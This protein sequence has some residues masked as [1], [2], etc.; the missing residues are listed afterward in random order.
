M[1]IIGKT[2]STRDKTNTS[3]EFS[4]WLDS[5]EQVNPT[6]IVVT[7]NSDESQSQTYGLVTRIENMSDS[8]SHLDNFV[9]HDF[10]NPTID[11][12]TQRLSTNVARCAVLKN[13]EDIYMPVISGCDVAFADR[14]GILTALGV[15]EVRDTNSQFRELPIGIIEQ[16][17]GLQA[18]AII[19]ARYLLGPEG[20]H[21]NISGI[22]G[23]AA[24]TSY[25]M[26]LL[27]VLLQKYMEDVAV[28]IFNVKQDDLLYIDQS[29]DQELQ[30]DQ[31]KLWDTLGMQP[32]QFQNVK[33]FLPR[34][35]IGRR[36]IVRPNTFTSTPP[37]H[38]MYAYDLRSI[39]DKLSYL[40]VDVADPRDALELLIGDIMEDLQQQN[41]RIRRGS[42]NFN[43]QT[44]VDLIN[45]FSGE[46]GR[47]RGVH[48]PQTM[49]KF[50]RHMRHFTQTGT[51]GLFVNNRNDDEANL[52]HHIWTIRPN[53]VYVI[54]IAQLKDF[55]R[56]FVVGD[57]MKEVYRLSSGEITYGDV[58]QGI[59][60]GVWGQGVE[61]N[62]DAFI[63]RPKKIVF[64][65][66]E[67]NKY[68]PSSR[69]DSPILRDLLEITERGRSLGTIL[70]GVEQFASNIHSRVFGNCSNKVYG[71]SDSTELGDQ[72]YRHI[73]QDLKSLITRLNQ[74]ELLLQHPLYRQPV[75]IRFPEPVYRQPSQ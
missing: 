59:R 23:L 22:S 64:F 52:A 26:F 12:Q 50:A 61:C 56:A 2:S 72:A 18:P 15:G 25:A 44:F 75:Q 66:D 35:A 68:A 7:Q 10:G 9:S 37:D 67:L 62:L 8:E 3:D 6:D 27:N 16:S 49:G 48:Y 39:K 45:A 70:L 20:A 19:D 71:R 14:D 51:T 73:P 41:P 21:F 54:D 53:Q 17:N 74:G 60:R 33:Y 46:G 30:E 69:D 55:E 57:V 42:T 38:L 58:P 5:E 29:A 63:E 31:Q 4:L 11:P 40:F 28:I 24:K 65:V 47:Y 32:Q 34:G 36:R 1:C 13:T 43:V